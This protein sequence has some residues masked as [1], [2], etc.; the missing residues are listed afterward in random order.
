MFDKE[1]EQL[2]K[3]AYDVLVKHNLYRRGAIRHDT[4]DAT[5]KEIGEAIDLA[6]GT[7]LEYLELVEECK[8][9]K[10]AI[11]AWQQKATLAKSRGDEAVKRMEFLYKVAEK[12]K[13]EVKRLQALLARHKIRYKK[14]EQNA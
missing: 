8:K 6:A 13:S 11:G 14:E 3:E 7:I 9:L 10:V 4:A 2:L 1:H 5:P 12:R